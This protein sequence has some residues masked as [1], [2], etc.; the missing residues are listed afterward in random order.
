[1]LTGERQKISKNKYIWTTEEEE[2]SS[3]YATSEIESS[4]RSSQEPSEKPTFLG[5]IDSEIVPVILLKKKPKETDSAKKKDPLENT[6]PS[7]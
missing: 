5:V 1:M 6:A 7:E 4:S 3:Q 2:L